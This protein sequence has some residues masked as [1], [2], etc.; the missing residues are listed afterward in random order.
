[1][2]RNYLNDPYYIKLIEEINILKSKKEQLKAIYNNLIARDK[3]MANEIESMYNE[4]EFLEFKND[5]LLKVQTDKL[6]KKAL[7]IAILVAI[8][9]SS[10]SFFTA[11]EIEDI[12]MNGIIKTSLALVCVFGALPIPLTLGMWLQSKLENE[13]VTEKEQEIKKTKE[14]VE[15]LSR[16]EQLKQEI[17]KKELQADKISIRLSSID[18]RINMMALNIR[19]REIELQNP[20]LKKHEIDK[21]KTKALVMEKF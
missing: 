14:F 19:M 1:M 17:E 21:P 12:E 15:I 11:F 8:S 18:E 4:M 16:I 20:H 6:R 5:E 9:I 10:L 2:E 7:I 13:Y 3:L